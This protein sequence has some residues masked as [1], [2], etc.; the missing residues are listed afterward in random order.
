M[1]QR[2]C[3]CAKPVFVW[4]VLLPLPAGGFQMRRR[5]WNGLQPRTMPQA[6]EWCIDFALDKHNLSKER[7][8]D[9][10]ALPTHSV[11]YKWCQTGKIPAVQ[12][13]NLEHVCGINFVTRY[14][15]AANGKLLIDLPTGRN[16]NA[17]DMQ[18]LQAT[19]HAAAGALL[20]FYAGK[21]TA[22]DTLDAIHAGL[23]SLA[24]HRGNV[25]Q[26]AQPQLELGDPS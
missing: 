18:H 12:I 4:K 25:Q 19:L 13:P 21:Q 11:L 8:A 6:V 7:I 15:A 23:Q 14:L 17:E 5:N 20:T 26:H 2:H 3:Q 1:V 22:A 16:A 24:W 9:R 10:M